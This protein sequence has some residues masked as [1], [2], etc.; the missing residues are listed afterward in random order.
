MLEPLNPNLNHM[1]YGNSIAI[2]ISNSSCN[3][4]WA[5]ALDWSEG[6]CCRMPALEWP[7]G[8]Q[9]RQAQS[10]RSCKGEAVHLIVQVAGAL[11]FATHQH[12]NGPKGDNQ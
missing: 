12:W 8:G 9:S 4:P 10:S 5:R 3:I 7:K 11:H 6:R 1:L 2:N